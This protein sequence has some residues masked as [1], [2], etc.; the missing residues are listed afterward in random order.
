MV[1]NYTI[2]IGSIQEVWQFLARNNG[3]LGEIKLITSIYLKFYIEK[4]QHWTVK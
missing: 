1:K 2:I 3:K 4:V